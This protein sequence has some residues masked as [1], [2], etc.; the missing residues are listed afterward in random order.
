[1]YKCLGIFLAWL[2]VSFSAKALFSLLDF[3]VAM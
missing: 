3:E 2:S 1:M